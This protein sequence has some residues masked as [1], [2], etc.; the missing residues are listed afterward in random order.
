M[1]LLKRITEAVKTFP[2]AKV[3]ANS[4]GIRVLKNR[5]V[6]AIDHVDTLSRI[7]RVFF[8]ENILPNVVRLNPPKLLFVGC[9]SYTAAYCEYWMRS[10]ISCWTIDID[11]VAAKWGVP[12]RHI[13]GDVLHADEMFRESEFDVSIMNGVFGFGIETID[14]MDRAVKSIATITKQG[15]LL[16]IG[17]NTDVISDPADLPSIKQHFRYSEAEPFSK[18]QTFQSST[19]VYDFYVKTW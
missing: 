6:S 19:H 15:G 7:D 3:L 2:G 16:I 8:V 13:I 11:P 4:P 14:E 5:I 18:R 9:R 1:L 17:W 10:K 12:G